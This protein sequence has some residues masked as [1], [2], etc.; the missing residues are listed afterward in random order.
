[1]E[2]SGLLAFAGV[3]L[4]DIVLSGDNAVVIGAMAASLPAAQ[5][6]KA[7]FWGMSIA[8]AARI[9]FSLGAVY[10]LMIPG[11]QVIGA[12][13]LLWVA[14]NMYKDLKDDGT[15]NDSPD[16][17]KA[18]RTF[19]SAMIAITVADIS[20]SIDNVL[21]VAGT[22]KDHMTALIFGLLLSIAIMAFA[23]NYVAKLIEKF[24]WVAWVG[25]A[26]ILIIAGKMFYHGIPE[27]IAYFN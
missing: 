13:A 10:L 4:I 27:L 11:I 12:A 21:A 20:M 15:L 26:F 14:Y 8:V 5:R 7:I 18:P 16:A 1:M 25:F 3:I 6:S 24:A 2:L 23:A 22:A 17:V 19:K 9:I